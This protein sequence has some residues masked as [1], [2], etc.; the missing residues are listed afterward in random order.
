MLDAWCE[1]PPQGVRVPA[2]NVRYGELPLDIPEIPS[3]GE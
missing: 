3:E 1:L 2:V